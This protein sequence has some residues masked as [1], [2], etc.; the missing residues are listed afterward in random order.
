MSD[1]DFPTEQFPTL[2]AAI[3]GLG[4]THAERQ[5]QLGVRN[6]RQVERLLRRLPYPM[7]PFLTG[8]AAPRLLR[9]LLADLEKEAA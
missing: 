9:A 2:R 8:K 1:F 3:H 6:T 4:E 5:A 7:A